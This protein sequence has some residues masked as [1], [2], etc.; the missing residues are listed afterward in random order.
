MKRYLLVAA[1][2]LGACNDDE[3]TPT[4]KDAGT[5]IDAS[6]PIDAVVDAFVTPPADRFQNAKTYLEIINACTDAEKVTKNPV[7][8]LIG[9]DGKLP[10]LP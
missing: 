3:E 1:L 5:P 10:P 2:V 4:P 9:A 6:S 8:P 7:L